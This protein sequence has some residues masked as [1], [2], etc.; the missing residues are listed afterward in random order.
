M[1]KVLLVF[2]SI[3]TFSFLLVTNKTYAQEIKYP[4]YIMKAY[5]EIGSIQ[6]IQENVNTYEFQVLYNIDNVCIQSISEN[7]YFL[8][9]DVGINFRKGIN[10]NTNSYQLMTFTCFT[11][12]NSTR[13]NLRVTVNKTLAEDYGFPDY[14]T[15]DDLFFN[16][17]TAL[18]VLY[19]ADYGSIDYQ[20]GFNDGYEAGSEDG[21]L[22][23]YNQ[24]YD[25]GYNTGYNL[26]RGE[27]YDLG[28][29]I[30]YD[31]G[32]DIGYDEGL[33]VSQS[34]AYN[35]GYNDGSKD[36]FLAKINTWL[37]PAIILVF[38]VGIFVT[39]RRR[40]E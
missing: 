9:N 18:Y 35:K 14:Y 27:G 25:T 16:R 4:D 34:E 39:Y 10:R 28:Y 22:D 29:D 6:L 26:G 19:H 8:I 2:I 15:F 17:D 12:T 5:Y 23:G 30:G 1:K 38:I 7:E 20:T 32:Y 31:E 13:I 3:L 21:F 24:G 40:G 37:V 33:K 36:S 11:T